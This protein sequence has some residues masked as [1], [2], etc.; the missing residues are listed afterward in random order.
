MKLINKFTSSILSDPG[1]NANSRNSVVPS[2]KTDVSIYGSFSSTIGEGFYTRKGEAY[3]F[4][5]GIN[6]HSK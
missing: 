1:I 4:L 6:N 5:R 2:G 3:N